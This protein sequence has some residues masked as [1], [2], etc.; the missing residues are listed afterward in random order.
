[1][2]AFCS[3]A[4]RLARPFDP[5]GAAVAHPAVLVKE[6]GLGHGICHVGGLAVL[7]HQLLNIESITDTQAFNAG[8]GH[9]VLLLCGITEAWRRRR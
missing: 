7:V 8:H 3:E 5:L 9:D 4:S 1:V 6:I 2:N